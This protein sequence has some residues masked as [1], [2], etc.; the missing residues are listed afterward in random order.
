VQ[1]KFVS[2]QNLDVLKESN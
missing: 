1:S 2:K